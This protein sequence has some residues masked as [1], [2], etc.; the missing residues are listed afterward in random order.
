MYFFSG[1]ISPEEG[2]IFTKLIFTIKKNNE[3]RLNF[4]DHLL[5][6]K[7]LILFFCSPSVAEFNG[8]NNHFQ[9]QDEKIQ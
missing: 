8:M 3:K 5:D 6:L 1:Y 7:G 9:I 4:T 2:G